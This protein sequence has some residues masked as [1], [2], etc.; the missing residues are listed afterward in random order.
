MQ[1][2]IRPEAGQTISPRRRRKLLCGMMLLILLLAL[3]S[4]VLFRGREVYNLIR[5]GVRTIHSTADGDHDF[6]DDAADFMLGAR[7]YVNTRPEYDSTYFAGGYPPEGRGVCTDVIWKGFRAAGYDFKAMVD[8]DI[9]QNPKAYP[10]PGGMPDTNIDFRRVVNLK[11]FFERN[12]QS[13]TT[14]AKQIDQWQGGDIVV[15]AGHIG[16][17][18]DHRNVRGVPYV[19]HHNSSFQR[20]YEEDIL[21]KRNDIVGHYRIEGLE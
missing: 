4:A 12:G 8:E 13:L 14:D 11:V 3:A 7:R 19:I 5:H 6:V 17:V 16:M 21:E 9:A 18:S 1:E 10:L 15:F 2:E 20:R